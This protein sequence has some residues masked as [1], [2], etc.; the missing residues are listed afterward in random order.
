MAMLDSTHAASAAITI[1]AISGRDAHPST[2]DSDRLNGD[3]SRSTDGSGS[4]MATPLPAS[5]L[6]P[7]SWA[8][9]EV[10]ADGLTRAACAGDARWAGA[11]GAAGSKSGPTRIMSGYPP[12]TEVCAPPGWL[13]SWRTMSPAGRTPVSAGPDPDDVVSKVDAL[14]EPA[15]EAENAVLTDE[16]RV[17]RWTGPL[18]AVF[19]VIL[20]PWTTYLAR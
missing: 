19:S 8:G 4:G 12:I 10:T 6:G 20:L 18:F 11:R 7:R 5:S 9:A 17:V 16:A 1:S 15:P 3:G 2:C 13:G 14:V